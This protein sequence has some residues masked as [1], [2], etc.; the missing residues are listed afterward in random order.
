MANEEQIRECIKTIQ[1]QALGP[2]DVNGRCVYIIA[3][4]ILHC[5]DLRDA[6]SKFPETDNEKAGAVRTVDELLIADQNLEDIPL[7]ELAERAVAVTRA[8]EG[9]RY[10]VTSDL[11]M[12]FF[13][14]ISLWLQNRG[15][16]PPRC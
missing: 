8:V 13:I 16:S 6:E 7:D 3:S 10:V 11:A 5:F 12:S 4:T 14:A 9:H 1:W 2:N 15:I